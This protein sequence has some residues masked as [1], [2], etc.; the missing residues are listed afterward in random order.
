[1]TLIKLLLDWYR[2]T[3]P[4]FR[5]TLFFFAILLVFYFF[6]FFVSL[7]PFTYLGI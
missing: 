5:L 7:L 4:S 3:R 6:P 1:M 2:A